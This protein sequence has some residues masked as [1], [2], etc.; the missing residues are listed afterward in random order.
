MP[1]P[2]LPARWPCWVV[3]AARS[4]SG[5]PGGVGGREACSEF[6]PTWGPAGGAEGWGAADRRPSR[7]R[8]PP[9]S[10]PSSHPHSAPRAAP[11][12]A[13]PR[14]VERRPGEPAGRPA[15]GRPARGPRG[16][17]PARQP[18]GLPSA[19]WGTHAS[20]GGL[21]RA[22]RAGGPS[23]P[24]FPRSPRFP[25]PTPHGAALVPG[26]PQTARGSGTRV[27]VHGS[28][29]PRHRP[30]PFPSPHLSP[31]R[32]TKETPGPRG[33]GPGRAGVSRGGGGSPAASRHGPSP[34][35]LP[36]RRS[37]CS[38]RT[39]CSGAPV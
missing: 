34:P 6:L 13:H 26:I 27:R 16:T 8:L 38:S 14:P 31:R 15:P 35:P 24:R 29:R 23:R 21:N 2:R 5:A 22:Q 10:P 39:S 32:A 18:R 9:P 11:A 33:A 4:S 1:S 20:P 17:R 37:V 36:S 12:G 25:L 30:E 19:S 3:G 28:R 7:P